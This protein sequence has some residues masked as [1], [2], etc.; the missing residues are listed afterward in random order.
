MNLIFLIVA[1]SGFLVRAQK[2][3]LPLAK[4]VTEDSPNLQ[5]LT[6]LRL[7]LTLELSCVCIPGI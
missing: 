7:D 4:R 1:Q 5:D 6:W 2:E 3:L